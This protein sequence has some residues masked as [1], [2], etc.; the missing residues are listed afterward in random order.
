MDFCSGAAGW[1]RQDMQREAAMAS[2]KRLN[3]KTDEANFFILPS[4]FL[5]QSS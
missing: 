2:I 4:A 1:M 5:V 3:I